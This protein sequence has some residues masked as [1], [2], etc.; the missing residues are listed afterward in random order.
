VPGRVWSPNGDEFVLRLVFDTGAAESIIAPEILDEIGYSARAHGEQIAVMRSAVGREEGYM[1]RVTRF[2]CLGSTRP[3][4]AS[5]PRI[6][7]K[8]GASMD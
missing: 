5:M 3:T 2:A 1:L 8:A 7:R 6:F 4:S